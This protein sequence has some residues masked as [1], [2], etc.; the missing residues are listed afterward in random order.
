MIGFQQPNDSRPQIENSS[1][2]I[3][4]DNYTITEA[5][6]DVQVERKERSLFQRFQEFVEQKT[7]VFT[8]IITAYALADIVVKAWR[9][10]K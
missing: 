4:P 1:K 6:T 10:F 8:G 5:D 2:P 9:R 7:W 3:E